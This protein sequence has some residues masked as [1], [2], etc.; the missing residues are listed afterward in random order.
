MWSPRYIGTSTLHWLCAINGEYDDCSPAHDSRL[1]FMLCSTAQADGKSQTST[2]SM[3]MPA[4]VLLSC[5]H[6]YCLGGSAVVRALCLY[7]GVTS[8]A[9]CLFRPPLRGQGLPSSSS[10][11]FSRTEKGSEAQ[12]PHRTYVNHDFPVCRPSSLVTLSV[13]GAVVDLSYSCSS[14]RDSKSLELHPASCDQPLN[15]SCLIL[16]KKIRP[17]HWTPDEKPRNKQKNRY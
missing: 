11:S 1:F 8:R 14:R 9:P 7:G 15:T 6:R 12:R 3:P 5:H 13:S 4:R 2:L 17:H 10:S 16:E